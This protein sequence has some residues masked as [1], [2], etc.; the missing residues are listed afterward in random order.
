M[1]ARLLHCSCL[2]PTSANKIKLHEGFNPLVSVEPV[3]LNSISSTRFLSTL[4]IHIIQ[5]A[6]ALSF[7][8]LMFLVQ[9]Y[10]HVWEYMQ[11]NLHQ[12][13]TIEMVM[14]L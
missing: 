4:N 5:P 2:S 13:S 10:N 9:C 1:L 11:G 6:Y 7:V 8:L 3:V 12:I 14:I